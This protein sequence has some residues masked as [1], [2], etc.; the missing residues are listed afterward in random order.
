MELTK[1]NSFDFSLN[2]KTLSNVESLYDEQHQNF[3]IID[4]SSEDDI[5]N[6]TL[7]LTLRQIF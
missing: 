1:K 6:P 3:L 5:E 4:S 2:N 7:K